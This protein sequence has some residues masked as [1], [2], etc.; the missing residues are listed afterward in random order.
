MHNSERYILGLD[1][2][3]AQDYSALCVVQRGDGGRYACRYLH[4]FPL[5]TRYD[6]VVDHVWTLQ[7]RRPLSMY[8]PLVIDRTGVGLAV[9][10]LFSARDIAHT[11]VVIHGGDTVRREGNVAYV[12]KRD[13]VA[14]VAVVLEQRRLSIASDM[15][16]ADLLA[17]EL[18][19]F[20]A[21]VSARGHD[22]YGAGEDW[23]TAPHDDMVLALAIALWHGSKA[24]ARSCC[25][26]PHAEMKRSK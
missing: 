24:R 17:Q 21:T 19:G 18:A 20:R 26:A 9:C 6:A 25:S 10:E 23:R 22:S 4:R 16:Y 7:T 1:L 11:G 5:G 3:Q 8:S 14:T 15:P 12:P 13:L 2:G